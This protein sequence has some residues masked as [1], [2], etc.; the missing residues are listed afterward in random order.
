MNALAFLK[1]GA[2]CNSLITN[3]P[4]YIISKAQS[5]TELQNVPMLTNIL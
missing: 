1:L 4:L 5:F 3:K 2:M